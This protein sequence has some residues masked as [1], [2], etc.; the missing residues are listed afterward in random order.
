MRSP[1]PDELFAKMCRLG[2]ALGMRKRPEQTPLEYAAM[3]SEAIPEQQRQ[4][5]RI[6][7]A[8]VL[9]RYASGRVP[10]SDLRDAGWS[11]SN[12]RWAMIK[13]FFRVRPA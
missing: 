5:R 4:I 7:R 3:L 6:T 12:L 10:L 1:R 2:G 13:R 8:Y 11:W 9:R